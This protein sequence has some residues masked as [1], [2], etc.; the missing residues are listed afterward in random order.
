M[1]GQINRGSLLGELIF[2]LV[3]QPDVNIVIEIGTWNGLGS[4]MCVIDGLT[5][6]NNSRFIS[7]ESSPKMYEE[8]L[9]NV[10]AIPSVDLWL[11]RI[12][13]P[14]NIPI[15]ALSPIQ[16]SWLL[17]DINNYKKVPNVLE[18]LP[19]KADLIIF[20]GGEFT[21]EL[22]F[23]IISRRATYVILDDTNDA[24]GTIKFATIRKKI[25][26][27]QTE[28]VLVQDNLS[29]RN[30]WLFAKKIKPK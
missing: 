11:G 1:P 6:K 26:E 5:G 28:F 9:E 13:E 30:G 3:S 19:Q 23:N 7:I 22:E 17:E 4:T 25:L 21:S 16:K 12:I 20:D 29:D 18:K 14:D 15:M 2:N 8:A 10:G 27:G 24:M